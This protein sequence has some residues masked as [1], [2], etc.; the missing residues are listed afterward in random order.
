MLHLSTLTCAKLSICADLLAFKWFHSQY[1]LH[2]SFAWLSEE[3]NT[4]LSSKEPHD[5]ETLSLGIPFAVWDA[6]WSL[7]ILVGG[8]LDADL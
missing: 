5:M 8:I 2:A 4:I 3:E 1:Y 6:A 7:R